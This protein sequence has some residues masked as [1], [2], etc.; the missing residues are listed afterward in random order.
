MRRGVFLSRIPPLPLPADER[1]SA[2]EKKLC[3]GLLTTVAEAC[4]PSLSR[5]LQGALGQ[6]QPAGHLLPTA[7]RCFLAPENPEATE[8]CELAPSGWLG[9]L[10]RFPS[11]APQ[12]RLHWTKSTTGLE[13]NGANVPASLRA[14]RQRRLMGTRAGSSLPGQ[15]ASAGWPRGSEVAPGSRSCRARSRQPLSIYIH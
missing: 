13:K 8:L 5:H 9:D 11:S 4:P 14:S 2:S 12:S 7:P 3:Q 10:L 15:V 6:A 1:G